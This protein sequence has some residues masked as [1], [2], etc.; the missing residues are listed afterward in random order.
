[1][2]MFFFHASYKDGRLWIRASRF[3]KIQMVDDSGSDF[4]VDLDAAGSTP[5]SDVESD[6]GS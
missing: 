5:N 4:G 3:P 1:M 6:C 2:D